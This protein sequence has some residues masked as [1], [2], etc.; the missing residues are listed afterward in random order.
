MHP[1]G[2]IDHRRH[3]QGG[4]AGHNSAVAG[5]RVDDLEERQ[6][7]PEG[8]Y[9]AMIASAASLLIFFASAVIAVGAHLGNGVVT[10]R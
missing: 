5:R 1:R 9:G 2:G 6:G 10:V 8:R 3:G 7:A 4:D